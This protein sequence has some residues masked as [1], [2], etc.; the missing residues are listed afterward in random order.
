MDKLVVLFSRIW[1]HRQTAQYALYMLIDACFTVKGAQTALGL[2]VNLQDAW[3]QSDT[4]RLALLAFV[5]ASELLRATKDGRD[6]ISHARN[7]R[8][9]RQK[10]TDS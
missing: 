9:G 5:L 3:Q 4:G 6:F 7:L 10:S 1:A 8:N 2:A